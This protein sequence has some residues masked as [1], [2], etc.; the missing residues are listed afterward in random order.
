MHI[1][2]LSDNF[3][4]EGNAPAT[5]AHEHLREWVKSG[6]SVTIITCVPNFPEGKVF[7]GYQ[8][9]WFQSE[10]IDGIK[11]WRVKTYITANEGFFKRS[12]DFLSFMITSFVFGIFT[13]NVDVVVGTSPQFFTVMSACCLARLKKVPFIFELRDI[14]PAS[15]AAV[16][17]VRQG[18]IIFYLEKIEMFLYQQADSIIAVTHSFKS[19]LASRGVDSCKIHVITNGVDLSFYRPAAQKSVSLEKIY[20]LS[21]KF[22]VGYIGTHGVAHALDNV[23]DAADYLK[24]Y[25]DIRLILAGGGSE[26]A[27]LEKLVKENNINNVVMIPK[28][29]K[30][31]M[32][33]L[34][35]VCDVALVHLKDTSLFKT[36]IP[37]KIFEAM[38]MGIPILLA[39][40]P[41]EASEIIQ[42]AGVGL[43]VPPEEPSSLAKAIIKMQNDSLTQTYKENSKLA[44]REYDRVQLAKRMLE[45]IIETHEASKLHSRKK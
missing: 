2:F 25:P 24:Q 5:R 16:G 13:R 15:I 27:R 22:V 21:D 8:N 23:L 44:A 19:E 11:V 33:A 28:Q 4:P 30:V 38:G 26:R 6:H 36:V 45:I 10:Q 41:G 37:S 7:D 35:S 18:K 31:I 20:G 9:R 29:S 43:V 3:P 40:P 1:L 14:W 34:W 32:P 12:L 42:E 39:A 17:A